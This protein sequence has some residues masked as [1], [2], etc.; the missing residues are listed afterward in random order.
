MDE[1]RHYLELLLDHRCAPGAVNCPECMRL[2]R[3]YQ[4]MQ[5]EIFSTVVYPE[6]HAELHFPMR[7]EAR[8]LNR[9]AAIPRSPRAA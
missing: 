7:P 5:T 9:A 2:R 8:P 1:L 4:F 3:I 6:R